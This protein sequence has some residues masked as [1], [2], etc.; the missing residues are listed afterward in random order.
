MQPSHAVFFK[1]LFGVLHSPKESNAFEQFETTAITAMS[2]PS[3][4]LIHTGLGG[5]N[6]FRELS[7]PED[8][9]VLS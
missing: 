2:P 3:G 1:K 4:L 8:A 9:A 5:Y 6:F 7:S